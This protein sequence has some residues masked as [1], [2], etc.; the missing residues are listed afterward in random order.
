M[1]SVR[2][3]PTVDALLNLTSAVLLL[4]GRSEIKHLRPDHHRRIMIS[5]MVSSLLFLTS[6]LIYHIQVG[7]VPYARY[8]WTRP[9]Y[10]IVLIPHVILAGLMTP[11]ILLAIIFAFRK[12][13]ANHKKVVR[14]VW[15]VW[16]FVSV[17]GIVVYLMLYHL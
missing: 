3:L 11:F 10:F 14:W 17:S 8:D 15:P 7:S 5:A 9:L 16:M 4:F 2:L 6:Y 13:F 1:I 12:N